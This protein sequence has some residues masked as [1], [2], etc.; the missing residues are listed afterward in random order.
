M[1]NSPAQQSYGSNHYWSFSDDICAIHP[2]P[3]KY[4]KDTLYGKLK[5]NGNFNKFCTILEKSSL[6]NDLMLPQANFTL[7]VVNDTNLQTVDV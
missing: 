6:I 3:I 7:F 4:N 1:Y 5:S 2:I